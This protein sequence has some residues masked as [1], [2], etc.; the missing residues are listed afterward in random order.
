[1]AIFNSYVKLPEGT[2][3][4]PFQHISTAQVPAAGFLLPLW[5]YDGSFQPLENGWVELVKH[6]LATK[7]PDHDL[8]P[9][10]IARLTNKWMNKCMQLHSGEME[11]DGNI[12]GTPYLA[13]LILLPFQPSHRHLCGNCSA[14]SLRMR[15]SP[16]SENLGHRRDRRA[17]RHFG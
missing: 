14:F 16:L 6:W 4:L 1:M 9:S 10:N 2:R 13:L 8:N 17:Q 11:I 15:W 7:W 3:F 5:L 12:N